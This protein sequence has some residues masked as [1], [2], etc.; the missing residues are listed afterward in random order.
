MLL[1]ARKKLHP[2]F[3]DKPENNYLFSTAFFCTLSLRNIG[4]YLLWENL[5]DKG[6]LPTSVLSSQLEG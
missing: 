5:R 1:I 4:P 3:M 2:V 6:M